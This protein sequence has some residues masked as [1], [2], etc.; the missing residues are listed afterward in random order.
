MNKIVSQIEEKETQSVL[1]TLYKFFKECVEEKKSTELLNGGFEELQKEAKGSKWI[2]KNFTMEP[3]ELVETGLTKE[4]PGVRGG[5]P[6]MSQ[7][8]LPGPVPAGVPGPEPL[9]RR[10]HHHGALPPR[11]HPH[12]QNFDSHSHD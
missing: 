5:L 11:N 4:A 6:A 10:T 8:A 2:R 1:Q 9:P 7:H 3:V 12:D